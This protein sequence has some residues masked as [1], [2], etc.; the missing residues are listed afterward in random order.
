MKEMHV[1]EI[2][3]QRRSAASIV[4]SG[5][6]S[7]AAK[8]KDLDERAA[9]LPAIRSVAR[10]RVQETAIRVAVVAIGEEMCTINKIAKRHHVE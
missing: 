3:D 2:A 5:R 6:K 8:I 10:R 1:I 4:R 7:L 9:R